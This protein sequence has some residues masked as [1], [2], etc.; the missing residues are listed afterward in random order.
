MRAMITML[1][2]LA[3]TLLVL[4]LVIHSKIAALVVIF[5]WAMAAFGLVPGLQSRVVDMARHAPNL[6]STLNIGAFN[7]G[8]AAGAFL[9]GLVIGQGYSLPAVPVAGAIVA[10]TGLAAALVGASR[11]RRR[12]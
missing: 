1:A 2:G 3:L 8:N 7:L 9:G 10:L 5:L 6:A 11:D 12:S 4:P